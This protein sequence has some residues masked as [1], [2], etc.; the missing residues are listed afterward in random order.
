MVAIENTELG[1]EHFI[2]EKVE[3][4][5]GEFLLLR[6]KESGEFWQ[7]RIWNATEQ[8]YIRKSTR[9]KRIDRAKRVGTE[10]WKEMLAKQDT[11]VVNNKRKRVRK[12]K[13]NKVVQE[14]K[15][16]EGDCKIV[17][18][19]QSGDVWQFYFYDRETQK[20]MRK[21]LKTRDT[22]LA[23]EK[24][25]NVYLDMLVKRKMG[26]TLFDRKAKE[27]TSEYI[28]QEQK[29]ADLGMITQQYV[30][31]LK[32]RMKHY[33]KFVG[34]NTALTKIKADKFVGYREFRTKERSVTLMTLYNE[35][36]TINALYKFAI[37]KKFIDGSYKLQFGKWE[38]ITKSGEKIHR[39]M[40]ADGQWAT[41]YLYMQ[42]WHMAKYVRNEKQAEQ[43]KFIREFTLILCNSGIRFGEARKLQW[44]DIEMYTENVI[45]DG[46]KAVKKRAKIHLEG[47][48][49]KTGKARTAISR[50]G[51][52]F[53]RLKKLSKHTKDNDYLFVDNDTGMQINKDVYY[54]NWKAMLKGTGLDKA[55]NEIVYYSLRHTYATWQLYK[56]VDV[57]SLS[58]VMGTGVAQIEAHYGQIEIDKIKSNFTKDL[59]KG[60]HGEILF[61]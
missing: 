1:A 53:E 50:I 16:F 27:L 61:G 33:L 54:K 29:R 56:G 14:I 52:T 36:S 31:T 13:G 22:N 4:L 42:K 20:T 21:T 43:R 23:K 32:T 3:V 45:E 35:R 6:T 44:R 24:A 11:K 40:L 30:K 9:Q 57:Y 55:H 25:H 19:A 17:R 46:K 60:E 59:K 41:I 10:Y 5:G 47:K 34:E 8:K 15:L 2:T 51:A 18:V 12:S 26:I 37:E 58:K 7:F 38:S 39:E 48:K 49:T 28:K